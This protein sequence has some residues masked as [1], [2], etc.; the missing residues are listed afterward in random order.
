[1][2]LYR[3]FSALYTT[4]HLCVC[5]TL[6]LS[7]TVLDP[8]CVVGAGGSQSAIGNSKKRRKKTYWAIAGRLAVYRWI[9]S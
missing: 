5:A 4:S 6:G 2:H 3:F 8:E 9:A 7:V 1:M